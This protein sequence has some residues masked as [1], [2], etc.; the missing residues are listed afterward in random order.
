MIF[1]Y[2]TRDFLKISNSLWVSTQRT[3]IAIFPE[4]WISFGMHFIFDNTKVQPIAGATDNR[5]EIK[6][7]VLFLALIQLWESLLSVGE[8]Q[9]CDVSNWWWLHGG[10]WSC[11]DGFL[12]PLCA[13]T[14]KPVAA[15]AG[16]RGHEVF[17]NPILTIRQFVLSLLFTQLL[18]LYSFS[19]LLA[20]E[21][22][23]TCT[24]YNCIIQ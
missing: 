18:C 15:I 16:E 1:W 2:W 24:V 17:L 8:H 3:V 7:Y 20:Y 4:N 22:T 13:Q 21:H 11:W 10:V 14:S 12:S 6:I 23:G 5:C 9:P 19:I